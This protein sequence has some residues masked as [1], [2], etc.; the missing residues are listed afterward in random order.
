MKYNDDDDTKTQQRIESLERQLQGL[1]GALRDARALCMSMSVRSE[2]L[3]VR[4]LNVSSELEMLKH[5]PLKRG[6]RTN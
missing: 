5:P 4:V 2:D 3:E 1:T 6:E